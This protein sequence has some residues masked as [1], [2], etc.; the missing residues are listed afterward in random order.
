MPAIESPT[1]TGARVAV[2]ARLWGA[3]AREP[4]PGVTSRSVDG[5]TLTVTCGGRTI[6]GPAAAARPFAAPPALSLN[7]GDDPG[8]VARQLWPGAFADELDN[9][10]ANLALARAA[11]P[12]PDGGPST[13]DRAAASPDPLVYT[14]QCVVDGHPLHPCCRT[15]MGLSP[16]EVR[17]YAPEHRPVVE[18]RVVVPPK[19]HWY[20]VQCPPWLFLHPWQVEHVLDRYPF[21]T[22]TDKRVPAHPLISLR[23]LA[24]DPT[25]HIKT[26]V[27][28][29]MT[30]AVRTVSAAAVH[31]GPLL[32]GL[33]REL[34]GRTPS[35]AVLPE[36]AAG[37]VVVD[38][39][40]VRSLAMVLRR[41]PALAPGEVALPLAALFAPSPATGRPI[42]LELVNQGYQDDP[43]S[44]VD[45]LAGLL[46][47]PLLRLL[48][49]GIGLEA[50]G[51]N[52]LAV[53]RGGRFVRLLYR[54]FGG[55]RISPRRL[56]AHGIE[57][58]PLRGDLV[59]DDP[60]VLRTKVFASAVSTVLG[61]LV[62]VLSRELGTDEDKAWRRVAGAARDEP[63]AAALFT[64][65]LPVK[66]TTAMRLAD[67]PV[68]D[69]WTV[70][71]NPMEGLR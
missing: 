49:L 2:L 9:S 46:L 54:D 50:H 16:A 38:D 37:A 5:D 61:E 71:D 62:T 45:A 44:C 31:N 22:L 36:V 19:K 40:P 65:P 56:A 30:S 14:E 34:A 27:D 11:Q 68:D 18:L 35:L 1:L 3:L 8:D 7:L 21:L 55:V 58:P 53:V 10:V 17:A 20:G 24:R 59:R 41:M 52:V 4:L 60:A 63:G 70:L 64:G 28:V 33:L 13:M 6:T 57:A 47:P 66:A 26:A 69:I 23:T 12:P 25:S 48:D 67:H 29:Q 32:S 42:V 43:L 15:R 51:Q 39:E